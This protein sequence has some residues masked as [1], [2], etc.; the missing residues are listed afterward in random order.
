MSNLGL[1]KISFIKKENIFGISEKNFLIWVKVK[2]K[3][4][5]FLTSSLCRPKI[6]K[7]AQNLRHALLDGFNRKLVLRGY[8]GRWI[9]IWDEEWKSNMVTRNRLSLKSANLLDFSKFWFA[10][11][12]QPF[13]IFKFW[14][15]IRIRRPK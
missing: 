2:K 5:I 9:R 12:D 7:W 11:F 4:N 8:Y 6:A 3:E 10:I 13:W 1:L 15:R 14:P